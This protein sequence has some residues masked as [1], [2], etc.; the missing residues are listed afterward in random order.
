VPPGGLSELGKLL[1][2]IAAVL[3]VVGGLLLLADR[4]PGLPLG[5]LPGD[6]AFE[7]GRFRFYFP[8]ATSLL[9]SVVLSLVL[10]LASRR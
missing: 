1:L 4:V 2:G 8:L 5:K 9:V 3:A 10:W 6:L 7:R